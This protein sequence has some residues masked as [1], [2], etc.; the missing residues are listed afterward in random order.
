M[1]FHG[2][3]LFKS[4]T[5][6]IIES[7]L[8]RMWYMYVCHPAYQ[9]WYSSREAMLMQK[10][11]KLLYVDAAAYYANNC[12][13]WCLASLTDIIFF[14][15]I[16]FQNLSNNSRRKLIQRFITFESD[17]FRDVVSFK[18]SQCTHLRGNSVIAN[19]LNIF[20][21]HKSDEKGIGHKL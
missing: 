18:Y 17:W 20:Y 6:T 10:V 9:T 3:V 11:Q 8:G 2:C 1:K 15:E 5:N 12:C 7:E 13:M 4:L 16:L 14:K 19:S 21:F